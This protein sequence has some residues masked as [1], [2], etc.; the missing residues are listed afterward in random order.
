MSILRQELESVLPE[1]VKAVFS[2]PAD[3]T[4]DAKITVRPVMLK[5]RTVYQAERFRGNKAYHENLDEE[6]FLRLLDRELDGRYR[7]V[8]LATQSENIQYV[9]KN[10]GSHRRRGR[11]AR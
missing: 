7:Q 3:S 2:Q 1:L 5:G 8:L 11:G 6:G 10:N 4:S 9:L